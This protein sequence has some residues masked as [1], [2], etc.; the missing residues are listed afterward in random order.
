M[1]ANEMLVEAFVA[2]LAVERFDKRVL[3]WLAGRDEAQP[4][5]KHGGRT[6][7]MAYQSSPAA[8]AA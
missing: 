4:T 8:D 5:R 3:D 2:Q 6:P 1:L 7:D